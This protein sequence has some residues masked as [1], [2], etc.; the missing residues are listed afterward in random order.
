[1]ESLVLAGE[2]ATVVGA[3]SVDLAR[4]RW[5]LDLVP[6]VHDPGLF[7]IASAVRMTGPLA[8]PRFDPIPLD[9]VAG[10]LRGLA[11]GAL[12]PAHT[13]ASGAQRVL[14]P[15]GKILAPLRTGL[16]LGAKESIAEEAAACVLPQS[17]ASAPARR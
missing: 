6:E 12:L 14:G 16:R 1:V 9:L 3:G 17:Q 2:R 7:E 13:V 15:L 10:T 4:E 8:D 11:R 5:H